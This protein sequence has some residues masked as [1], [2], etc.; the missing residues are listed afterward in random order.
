MLNELMYPKRMPVTEIN[1][2]RETRGEEK[3][4]GSA[5]RPPANMLD[6]I[7]TGGRSSWPDAAYLEP[8]RK[9]KRPGLKP[10]IAFASLCALI[11]VKLGYK[12][13]FGHFTAVMCDCKSSKYMLSSIRGGRNPNQ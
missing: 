1:E 13:D 5:V 10:Q 6:R 3:R 8:R 4:F 12:A 2:E 11:V 9:H 7:E